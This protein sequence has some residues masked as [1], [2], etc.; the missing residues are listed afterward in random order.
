PP[1]SGP[2]SGGWRR[3]LGPSRASAPE[4]GAGAAH[5]LDTGAKPPRFAAGL[6]RQADAVERSPATAPQDGA[7]NKRIHVSD[8]ACVIVL[9]AGE[10]AQRRALR[11]AG[12]DLYAPGR[13]PARDDA[14]GGRYP[15]VSGD[16]AKA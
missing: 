13:E 3:R 1:K 9:G 16:Q 10:G 14:G 8:H 7:E 2:T 6:S 11:E 4:H 5:G 12:G 15:A